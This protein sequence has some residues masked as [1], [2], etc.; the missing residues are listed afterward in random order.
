MEPS[1][2]RV[3]VLA[4]RTQLE[5]GM[6]LVT[7][8]RPDAETVSITLAVR[9]GARFETEDTASAA[10][11]LEH[12][13]LQGTPSRP[14]RDEVLRTVTSRG[15]TLNVGT[16]W[17][18][19]DLTV[20]MAPEDFTVAVDLLWDILARSTF[21][22]DRLEHQ[23]GLIL[24]ELA[25]RRDSPTAV[26]FD[27]FYNTLFRS[28]SLRFLPSGTVEGV[29]RMTREALVRYRDERVVPAGIVAG[30]VSP[31]S[32]QEV[33]AQ[34]QRT[35]GELP[36]RPAP[37]VAGEPP[38]TARKQ[39]V[40]LAAGRNQ[41]TVIL[42]SPTPGLNHPDRYPL[43]MLQTILGP[44]GGRL[45]YD[46][47][48]VHGLAYDT[49]MRLALTAESGS[50]MA[51]AGTDP[52]NVDA[53]VQ[54]LGQHL[55]RMRDEL[56]TEKERE[57][58]IGFLVGGTVVGL[59]SGAAFAGQLAHNTALGLPLTTA[60]LEASLRAVTRE[61][62]QRVAQQYLSADLLTRVVVRPA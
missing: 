21:D 49:S 16:G 9:G 11:F 15:G 55:A 45:F 58:A 27:L 29:S 7:G 43:W 25:E 31:F 38:P 22:P 13:Y 12:M 62:I 40:D 52:D 19:L 3:Q 42:G 17:E 50:I 46:I 30:V 56:V 18:F 60:E 54:L 51:Y 35:L 1:P 26:A 20:V 33:L 53:V 36:K 28:H 23:R 37:S 5:N 4:E 61:E 41:A 39:E 32:H 47:R 6:S 57:Q 24:Q 10:H 44:G 48:D 34:F 8:R 2:L 59:E 14:S